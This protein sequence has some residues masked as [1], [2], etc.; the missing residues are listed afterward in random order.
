MSDN[1]MSEAELELMKIIWKQKN[2]KGKYSPISTNE[3]MEHLNGKWNVSTV[4]TLLT[5]LERKGYV[6]SAKSG[7]SNVYTAIVEER[8]YL[9]KESHRIIDMLYDGSIRNL[10]VSFCDDSV[11][12]S[13][14]A[15]IERFLE[16]RKKK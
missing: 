9:G 8:D 5:R 13:E 3:I 6:V 10:L 1:L 12:D 15:E 7:R 2:E 16:E 4:F 11:S 14:I